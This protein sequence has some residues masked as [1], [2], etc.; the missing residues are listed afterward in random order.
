LI[1]NQIIN[2]GRN[3]IHLQRLPAGVHFYKVVSDMNTIFAGKIEK[4]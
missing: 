3:E 2:D 4:Q 1:Q